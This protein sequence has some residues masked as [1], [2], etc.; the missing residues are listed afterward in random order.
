MLVGMRVSM[1]VLDALEL[2]L[3]MFWRNVAVPVQSP[4]FTNEVVLEPEVDGLPP[5]L[6]EA[7]ATRTKI[8][9]WASIFVGFRD[10]EGLVWWFICC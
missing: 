6:A 4:E 9:V 1:V 8:R 10:F 7:M 3:N 5:A 2:E